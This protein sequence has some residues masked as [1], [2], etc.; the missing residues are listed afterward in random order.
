M[1]PGG[2]TGG[3]PGL[4][5][6]PPAVILYEKAGKEGKHL[7]LFNNAEE[8]QELDDRML[9]TALKSPK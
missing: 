3:I 5:S 4:P 6:G 1:A 7:V 2:P 9:E 8:T